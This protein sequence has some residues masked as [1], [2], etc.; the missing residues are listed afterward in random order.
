MS[1]FSPVIEVYDIG[2]DDFWA[3]KSLVEIIHSARVQCGA[4]LYP[5]TIKAVPITED[6]MNRFTFRDDDGTTRTFREQ[7]DKMIA[8]GE[9]FPCCFASGDA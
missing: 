3:G 6:E 8:E 4:H 5:L 9:T 1:I 7:L 2:E